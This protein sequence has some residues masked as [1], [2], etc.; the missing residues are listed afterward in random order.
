MTGLS[1]P[2]KHWR[3]RQKHW[4]ARSLLNDLKVE[5]C[6]LSSH[7][8]DQLRDYFWVD[9][10]AEWDSRY[11]HQE[12]LH[13]GR[14]FSPQFHEFES[15][16]YQDEINHGD[17]FLVFYSRLF[18]EPESAV[19]KRL[20][21]RRADF[22]LVEEFLED[23]FSIALLFAYD[24]LATIRAYHLDLA[25]YDQL[26]PSICKTWIRQLIR[27][28]SYHHRNGFELAVSNKSYEEERAFELI[29]SFLAYD[30]KQLPYRA[31]FIFDHAWSHVDATFFRDT[32]EILEKLL[33]RKSK[34]SSS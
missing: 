9:L 7:D 14:N 8:I 33:R 34:F 1:D 17:G 31:T 3:P 32:A 2:M 12:L 18:G 30:S 13:R 20:S 5:D 29:D 27:D 19:E 21:Q 24:E 25:L 23:E 4:S 10:C 26:G 22:S 11:L 15:A 28:E 16:W 6:D